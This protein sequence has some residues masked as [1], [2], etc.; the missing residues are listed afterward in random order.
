MARY[1]VLRGCVHHS[2]R[3]FWPGE[4]VELDA[5]EGDALCIGPLAVLHR[6]ADAEPVETPAPEAEP[7]PRRRRARAPES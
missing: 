5:A 1:R 3:R 7:K 2:G 6:L 4:V